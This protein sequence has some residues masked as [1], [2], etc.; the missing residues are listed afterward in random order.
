MTAPTPHSS[1]PLSVAHESMKFGKESGDQNFK[2]IALAV[3]AATAIATVLN[4]AH[5]VWKDMRDERRRGRANDHAVLPGEM[6]PHTKTAT[7]AEEWPNRDQRSWVHKA[8]LSE[9]APASEDSRPEYRD[10]QG[11]GRR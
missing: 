7:A 4:A 9:R 10:R 8:G 6:T 2:L 5:I 1:N 11:H 3:M